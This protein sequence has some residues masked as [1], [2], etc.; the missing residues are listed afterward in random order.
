VEKVVHLNE[1]FK[2]VFYSKVLELG[3][4][5][6]WVVKVWNKLKSFEFNRFWILFLFD[7]TAAALQC[8]RGP[9]VSAPASPIQTGHAAWLREAARTRRSG[10][11][12]PPPLSPHLP[13]GATLPTRPP[14]LR[15]GLKRAPPITVPPIPLVFLHRPCEHT[16]LSPRPLVRTSGRATTT[17]H[18]I[19]T[20]CRRR[21]WLPYMVSSPPRTSPLRSGG[22]SLTPPPPPTTG[23]PRGCHRSPEPDQRRWNPM[24]HRLSRLTVVDPLPV[25]FI[26]HDRTRRHP[27]T[28]PYSILLN[29]ALYKITRT[30]I[31]KYLFTYIYTCS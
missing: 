9:P 12:T 20:R 2:T 24:P 11:D 28:T 3:K 8:S 30:Q 29:G 18:R 7:S 22:L 27:L 17:P 14:T 21:R 10:R 4:G 19:S 23:A 15:V 26:Q 13:Y 31:L 1:V 6:F 25:S 16:P 5:I